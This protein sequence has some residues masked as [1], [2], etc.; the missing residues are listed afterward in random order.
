MKI[1]II[2][3]YTGKNKKEI[4]NNIDKAN[5]VGMRIL[6]KGHLPLV[7]QSMFAFWEK[8]IDMEK[9]MRACFSWIKECDAVLLLNQGSGGT[10]KALSIAK[11]TIR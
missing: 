3:S 5:Q 6:T 4:L 8:E 2:A 11:K 10:L 9:I 7:P 1:F